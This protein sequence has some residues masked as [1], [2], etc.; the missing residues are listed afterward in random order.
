MHL[1]GWASG[2]GWM[3]HEGHEYFF[4][5][6]NGVLDTM[7]FDARDYCMRE[8][9]DLASIHND[10]EKNFIYETVSPLLSQNGLFWE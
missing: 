10:E 1:T 6:M 5:H 9:G 2:Q 8:G 4:S 3:P 7:W